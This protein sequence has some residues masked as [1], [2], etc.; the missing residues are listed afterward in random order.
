[1]KAC[2]FW[3]IVAIIAGVGAVPAEISQ[4]AASQL[5][6]RSKHSSNH[7]RDS[8]GEESE[9]SSIPI[10]LPVLEIVADNPAPTKKSISVRAGPNKPDG[11][12]EAVAATEIARRVISSMNE[13]FAGGVFYRGDTRP[14]SEVFAHG[15]SPQGTD[16]D[17]H[18]HLN[19]AGNSRYVSL[20]LSAATAERYSRGRTGSKTDVGY[21]YMITPQ[22]VPNGYFIPDIFNEPAV[23][24]N[25]EFAAA[26]DIPASS[27]VG[28]YKV[29]KDGKTS[30]WIRN[31]RF[32]APKSNCNVMKRE[33]CPHNEKTEKPS[34]KEDLKKHKN[35]AK[36]NT[37]KGKPEFEKQT[38]SGKKMESFNNKVTK[39]R[40]LQWTSNLDPECF[41]PISDAIKNGELDLRDYQLAFK[42]ALSMV[43]SD[44]WSQ[45]DSVERAFASLANIAV[46]VFETIRTK[47]PTYFWR[48]VL[49]LLP[50][51]AKNISRGATPEERLELAN[52]DTHPAVVAWTYTPVGRVNELLAEKAAKK[53]P[54]AQTFVSVLNSVW[55]WTPLGWVFNHVFP[56]EPLI[57]EK[58][59]V[60]TLPAS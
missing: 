18:H 43:I 4:D 20:T 2:S 23:L 37:P 1:M 8:H 44:R 54:A 51:V 31:K 19:F 21:V 36:P 3:G 15:F 24:R 49:M 7:G 32:I 5:A 29:Y 60:R 45:F 59:H 53:A 55:S 22:N 26:G 27:I 16:A 40:F 42:R 38:S 57:Q 13:E 52:H 48:D 6:P 12:R 30:A 46:D 41:Q 35:G 50:D 56:L 9:E 25:F 33:L 39:N 58:I 10:G 11:Q 17:L 47:V 34:E 28:C 14:P